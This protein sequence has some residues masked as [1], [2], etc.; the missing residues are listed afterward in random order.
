[1][2]RLFKK[3]K[4]A[5]HYLNVCIKPDNR[6]RN[7]FY[8]RKSDPVKKAVYLNSDHF[9]IGLPGFNNE[10][11]INQFDATQSG[12][13]PISR[14]H[15]FI[16]YDQNRKCHCLVDNNSRTGTFVNGKKISGEKILRHNDVIGLIPY[17]V[18]G[19]GNKQS[20]LRQDFIVEIKFVNLGP[21]ITS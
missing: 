13:P 6:N 11:E 15:C 18:K 5:K 2:F 3:K 20:Y 21:S 14:R 7:F 4:L 12:L 16:Q 1:M 19:I 9:S 8:E 17:E 10:L